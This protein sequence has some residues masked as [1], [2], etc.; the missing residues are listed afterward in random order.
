MRQPPPLTIRASMTTR[1]LLLALV[2][3]AAISYR[4]H[5]IGI[6]PQAVADVLGGGSR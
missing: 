4:N 5:A 1:P 3:L 6:F 2:A